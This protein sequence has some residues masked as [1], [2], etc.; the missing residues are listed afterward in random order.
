MKGAAIGSAAAG[1]RK[2]ILAL[3]GGGTRQA[4]SA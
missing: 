4:P 2:V 3:S 1:V